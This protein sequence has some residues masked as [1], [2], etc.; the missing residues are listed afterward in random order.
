MLELQSDVPTLC[1]LRPKARGDLLV[2]R[3]KTKTLGP[4]SFASAGPSLWNSLP[5]DLRE[6]S[7]SLTVFKHRLKTFLFK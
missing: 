6:Q 2:P 3:T 7:L 4:R 5:D 1:R